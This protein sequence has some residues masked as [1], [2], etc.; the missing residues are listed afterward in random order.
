[1]PGILAADRSGVIVDKSERRCVATFLVVQG[2]VRAFLSAAFL[3]K[4][5]ITGL[6]MAD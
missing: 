1:L 6:R 4:F 5:L 3:L 2:T